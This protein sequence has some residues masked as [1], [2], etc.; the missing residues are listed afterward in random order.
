MTERE[1]AIE[2]VSNFIDWFAPSKEINDKVQKLLKVA[3]EEG[4]RTT[5]LT[6][7]TVKQNRGDKNDVRRKIT[8]IA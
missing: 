4:T 1:K 3:T 2:A 7:H 5:I 8:K 6:F